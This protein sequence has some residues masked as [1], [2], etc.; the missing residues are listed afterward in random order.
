ML[1]AI[2]EHF[3]AADAHLN[4]VAYAIDAAALRAD[5]AHGTAQAWNG[6]T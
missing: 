5:E 2:L 3:R 1:H 4:N 6:A